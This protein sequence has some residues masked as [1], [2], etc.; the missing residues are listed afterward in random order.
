[1]AQKLYI[2]GIDR[3]EALE[4]ASVNIQYMLNN[5]PDNFACKLLNFKPT[6]GQ[7]VEYYLGSLLS[8]GYSAG[9]A[10]VVVTEDFSDIELFKAGDQI[11]LDPNTASEEVLEI[12]SFTPSTKTIVFT[13]NLRF[14]HSQN[15]L[16]LKKEFGGKVLSSPEEDLGYAG[17][18]V[19]SMRAT[20]YT[21]LFNRKNIAETYLDMYPLEVI[22]RF[23]DEYV[24][25]DGDP[26]TLDEA[27]AADWSNSGVAIAETLDSAD[28]VFGNSSLN[29]GASGAGTAT[30]TKTFSSVDATGYDSMRIWWKFALA[31]LAKI[32]T[33][34]LRMGS[35][36]SNYYQ[37]DIDP[38]E[39][40][41]EPWY[42]YTVKLNMY[43][44]VTGT[45]DLSGLT[46][47]GLI[48]EATEAISLGDIHIDR[49]TA[50]LNPFTVN[51]CQKGFK[52]FEDLRVKFKKP[53]VTIN[54]IAQL[55]NYYWRIDYFKNIHFFPQ[56]KNSA[57]FGIEAGVTKNYLDLVITPD[58]SE[59]KNR[60]IV[61][62]AEA[63]SAA[64]YEQIFVAD[65][66]QTSFTLD[67][68]PKDLTV[69][70]D[71]G[72]G[73]VSKT[74]GFEGVADE[75]SVEFI[76]NFNEKIVRNAT[77]ATLGAGDKIKFTYYPYKLVQVQA[78]DPISIALM[79]SIT[80]GDG[81]YDGD[82]IT[83]YSL[84]T[85]EE[86]RKRANAELLQ[87]ANP[88][89]N[90]DFETE[91]Q[92]LKAGQLI[93]V[94]DASR[95]VNDSYLIQQVMANQKYGER[96]VYKVKCASTLFGIIEFLQMLLEKQ[97]DLLADSDDFI[98][99][100]KNVN[101]IVDFGVNITTTQLSVPWLATGNPPAPTT[102]QD[103][104]A[105]LC[106]AL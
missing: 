14:N 78:D 61:R 93:S 43:T 20:D 98:D 64:S 65:G 69:E 31:T 38:A 106:E 79:A 47:V 62:G 50:R 25:D 4:E 54:K 74:V 45:P 63:P 2:N 73:Y 68:K 19:N 60:Q 18:T 87:Y 71:P 24:A 103:A 44:S 21:P 91:Y 3:T 37:W 86:T 101:E 104:Y 29:L 56:N 92:G 12:L 36:S 46:Y 27:E 89:I 41:E 23:V 75:A 9:V 83:D 70:V 67:Y 90:V 66:E 96:Y 39:L 52:K 34:S 84:K 49:I 28:K 13:Q 95:G 33:L 6:Y 40:I 100:L 16:V 72:G 94:V 81:I 53:S 8:T 80:G 32:T 85:Y 105:S 10:T 48:F 76:A 55:F 7:E 11:I 99:K 22:A 17:D 1:M 97:D 102:S 51:Y 5:R 42:F 15:G 77:H 57:P 30:Y 59:L 35:D 88:I 26:L 58:V 82:V